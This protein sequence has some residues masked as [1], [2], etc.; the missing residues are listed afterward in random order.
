MP[1]TRHVTPNIR[2]EFAR[3]AIPAVIGMVVS[4]LYNIVNGIFVGQGVGEMGLGTINIVYPFI[5][6]E[7]AITMPT[8]RLTYAKE[9]IWWIALFGI[10]YMP[11]LGLSIFVRNNNAPLTS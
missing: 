6:L 2:K 11:G 9:Y 10:I 8:C 1:K 7:I 4:S 5:M 3:F